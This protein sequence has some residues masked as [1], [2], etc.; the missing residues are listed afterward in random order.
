M[1]EP[2]QH[3]EETGIRIGPGRSRSRLA[4]PLYW[5]VPGVAFAV[6]VH[7][8][9][10]GAGAV[11]AFTDWNGT[12]EATWIGLDNF[13]EI[14]H[15]VGARSAL[16]NTIVLAT[17]SVVL[18]NVIGLGLALGLHRTIRSRN[19]LRAVFFA[20]V[21]LSSL[22][23]SYIW[24]FIFDAQ[25]PLNRFLAV[26]GLESWARPWLADPTWAKWTVLVVLVW[27][28]SGLAMAL[29]LAGLQGVPE[30]IEEAAAIDGASTLRRFRAIILPL[31][32]PAMTTSITLTTVFS[33]RVFDQVLA[34][35]GGGPADASE[36][37]ATQVYKQTFVSGRFG[38]GAAL[39][40]VLTA[41]VACVSIL[42][43]VILRNREKRL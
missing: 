32:A 7:F 3:V 5:A 2:L 19:F 10:V 1:H 25:G 16:L 21:V 24:Q 43:L 6:A 42:Q 13:R 29:Y 11:Y 12:G 27:Q 40:L 14:V 39:A 30:E 28:Y 9:L 37:L 20:P 26:V 33:L 35:T 38:Y 23:V 31:L 22:A 36:T 15:S 41:L 4:A 8:V 17:V 18:A 34:L